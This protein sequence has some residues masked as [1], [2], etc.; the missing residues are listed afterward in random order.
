MMTVHCCVL[1]CLSAGTNGFF[2]YP[3][4]VVEREKWNKAVGRID[5][6]PSRVVCERHFSPEDFKTSSYKGLPLKKKCLKKGVVPH[7][8]VPGKNLSTDVRLTQPQPK[9]VQPTLDKTIKD[10]PNTI[11]HST[12][13]QP[14]LE[15]TLDQPTLVQ[16]T[17]VQP[18]LEQPTPEKPALDQPT[19]CYTKQ[20]INP[21]TRKLEKDP[22]K[23]TSDQPKPA[24]NKPT[25]MCAVLVINPQALKV[26]KDRKKPA[27][28][29]PSVVQP[30]LTLNKPTLEKP[31]LDQ[32]TFTS[33]KQVIYPRTRELEKDPK[34]PALDQATLV[35]PTLDQPTLEKQALDQPTCTVLVINPRSLKLAKDRKKPDLDQPTVVQPNSQSL[36]CEKRNK[37]K[38]VFVCKEELPPPEPEVIDIEGP[39]SSR[40][41]RRR[42]LPSVST[43]TQT[44]PVIIRTK[45]YKNISCQTEKSSRFKLLNR[46]NSLEQKVQ[47]LEKLNS[48]LKR[49]VSVLSKRKV[50]KKVKHRIVKDTLAP[51]FTE[52][53]IKC[54]WQGKW[55][56][57]EWKREDITRAATLRSMLSKKAYCHL[58]NNHFLPLPSLSTLRK[59]SF[60]ITP[61]APTF[62]S[63]KSTKPV[64][65]SRSL[66]LAT[67]DPKKMEMPEKDPKKIEIPEKDLETIE[68]P[69]QVI[70]LTSNQ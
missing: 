43:S 32:P 65:K 70:N 13:V 9:M 37:R 10:T 7:L 64:I 68:I 67:K 8:H 5:I 46:C 2:R 15:P 44:N 57:K 17:L 28:D 66:K 50:T 42:R 56:G 58:R 29:Q 51:F 22:I 55:T 33:I 54:F 27:L 61:E 40:K 35:Q 41:V 39:T 11:V 21:L 59:V 62:T 69:E 25:S 18:K 36:E 52:Q 4:N 26:A 14:K 30:K 12:L 49:R 3:K 53:Q 20:V 34:K 60:N 63:K 1:R 38:Q 48:K 31:A 16:S 45:H 19:S 24:L 6:T 47:D 23:P